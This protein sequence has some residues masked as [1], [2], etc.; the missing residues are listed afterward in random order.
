MWVHL[1]LLK[2]GWIPDLL[3][4]F[5]YLCPHSRGTLYHF[6]PPTSELIISS[7]LMRSSLVDPDWERGA[8]G[9][10]PDVTSVMDESRPAEGKTQLFQLPIIWQRVSVVLNVGVTGS[11][12]RQKRG[13]TGGKSETCASSLSARVLPLAATSLLHVPFSKSSY[14]HCPGWM[15]NVWL[16]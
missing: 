15:G 13:D 6:Y 8:P 9:F 1:A 11:L 3:N 2:G 5:V 10:D 12:C 7:W 4:S 14:T 16:S